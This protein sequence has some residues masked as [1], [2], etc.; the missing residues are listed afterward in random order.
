MVP[1]IA[2]DH[3]VE[4]QAHVIIYPENVLLEIVTQR[5]LEPPRRRRAF[6]GTDR[7][8][9][10]IPNAR[11]RVVSPTQTEQNGCRAV[12][13]GVRVEQEDLRVHLVDDDE[14]Q[15]AIVAGPGHPVGHVLPIPGNGFAPEIGALSP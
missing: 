14:R 12:Q 9:L 11:G 15:A 2:D 8:Q 10:H 4:R 1:G 3:P 5:R 13:S 7:R 6:L